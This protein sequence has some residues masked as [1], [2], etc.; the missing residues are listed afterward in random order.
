MSTGVE[1]PEEHVAKGLATVTRDET[2]CP[3]DWQR[4]LDG[5]FQVKVS[6]QPPHN[7]AVS[8]KYRGYWFYIDDRDYRSK[9]T[10]LTLLKIAALQTRLGGGESLPVFTIPI[11]GR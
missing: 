5:S 4:V 3:F 7:A 6:K 9:T 2:G 11:G 10:Y 1:V 8:V